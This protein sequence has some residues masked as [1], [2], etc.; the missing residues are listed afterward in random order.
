[1]YQEFFITRDESAA[2]ESLIL[3]PGA[4][5][6]RS[7]GGAFRL[8]PD[9]LPAHIPPALAEKVFFIG[10]QYFGSIFI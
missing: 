10:K 6:S 9:L 3:L 8:R 5:Q 4:D 2:E 1:L 7:K